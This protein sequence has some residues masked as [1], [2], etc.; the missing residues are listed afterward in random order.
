MIPREQMCGGTSR[1][2]FLFLAR[3]IEAFLRIHHNDN[4]E[5]HLRR[6]SLGGSTRQAFEL[7]FTFSFPVRQLGINN[8]TLIRWTK[9]FDLPDAVGKDVCSLLQS[10]IDELDLPVRVA[11]LVNDTVGTLMARSYTS[12]GK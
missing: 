3:Q 11:A 7:G 8:G 4:F 1:D 2:L 9:G 12:V 10:A 5:A 6:R